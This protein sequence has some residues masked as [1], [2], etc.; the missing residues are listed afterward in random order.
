MNQSK[1][2]LERAVKVGI[3]GGS[4]LDDPR[5]LSDCEEKEVDTPY[6]KPSSNLVCGKIS[7]VDV[8]ILARHGKKHNIPP[9]VINYRANIYAL[10]QEGCIYILGTSA[11]GSLREEIK[12]GDLVF[13]DQ[14]I[15]FTKQRKTTFYDGVGE[16]RHSEMAYPFSEKLRKILIEKASELGF[17]KHERAVVAVIEGPRFSSKAESN[18]FRVLGADII[19]MTTVPEVIL[20]R[21]LSLEY[22][23]IATS[24]DYD[25]WKEGEESVTFDMILKRMEENA[26]K[27]RK[28]LLE[29]ISVL[30]N[31]K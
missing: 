21:E 6:G 25:C 29:V 4:G 17:R 5:L 30:G 12:P 14:F 8:C 16:F 27:V 20:A 31:K 10:Q 24:T 9:A 15:D 18:M 28:L 23:S 2:S 19:G 11:V 3:I 7:G 26:D 1:N 13:P 22:A